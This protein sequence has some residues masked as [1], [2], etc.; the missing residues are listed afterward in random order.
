MNNKGSTVVL[1]K[2]EPI[3]K[4]KTSGPED[5]DQDQCHTPPAETTDLR[6]SKINP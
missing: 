1:P 6:S 2:S 3:D 5:S 4:D